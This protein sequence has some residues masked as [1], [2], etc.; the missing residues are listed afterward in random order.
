MRTI[1]KKRSA[2][3]IGRQNRQKARKA[4]QDVVDL[5]KAAGYTQARRWPAN[6]PAPSGQRPSDLICE[7]L[8]WLNA[9]VKHDNGMTPWRMMDQADT[10]GTP[11][12]LAVGFMRKDSRAGPGQPSD[13]PLVVVMRP[14]AWLELVSWAERG[15]QA[16]DD[17]AKIEAELS[18]A[19]YQT[20]TGALLIGAK[21][22]QEV[23]KAWLQ[24]LRELAGPARDREAIREDLHT[25]SAFAGY[26]SSASDVCEP[27]L[28]R[29]AE[30]LGVAPLYEE[31]G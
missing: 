12:Q 29:L 15:R 2:A 24:E 5:L 17:V 1:L 9:E 8:P 3:A 27:E 30:D 6:M 23:A 20:E 22:T 21:Q 31:E 14:E 16:E 26:E 4:E 7:E 13:R 11:G 19:E 18:G 25:L 28:A 10:Q